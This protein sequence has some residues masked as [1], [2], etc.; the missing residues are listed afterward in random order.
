MKILDIEAMSLKAWPPHEL[1]WLDGWALGFTSGYTRRANSVFP[2]G[3]SSMPLRQ[4]IAQCEKLYTDHNQPAI[5]KLTN[6]P[7]HTAVDELLGELGYV[8]DAH[9]TVRALSLKGGLPTVLSTVAKDLQTT[10]TLQATLSD[11]WL[12][13]L[14]EMGAIKP[15]TRL[16]CS[17]ILGSIQPP[18]RFAAIWQSGKMIGTGLGVLQDRAVGLFDIY[19]HPAWRNQGIATRVIGA[20]LGWAIEEGASHAWLQVVDGNTNAIHLYEGMGFEV[21]Y[22]YWYRQ[23]V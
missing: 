11:D 6:D 15:E 16:P 10:P 12:M 17:N 5:F 7:T 8:A 2:L 3:P 1:V 13:G 19:T 18:C 20:L 4:Q 22:R 14:Q 21:L 9:T 23:K